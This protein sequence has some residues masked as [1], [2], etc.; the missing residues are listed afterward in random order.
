MILPNNTLT[1][2]GVKELWLIDSDGLTGR[3]YYINE[4]GKYD[5]VRNFDAND[6]PNFILFPDLQIDF[7]S[8]CAE[9]VEMFG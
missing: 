2:I 1:L 9:V 3:I 6:T 5:L 7:K 4:N 8:A